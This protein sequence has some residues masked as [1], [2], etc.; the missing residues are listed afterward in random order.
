MKGSGEVRV[1]EF[2]GFVT[3]FHYTS[4]CFALSL[5][6]EVSLVVSSFIQ[7]KFCYIDFD[8]EDDWSELDY[9]WV[10]MAGATNLNSFSTL[11]FQGGGF[12]V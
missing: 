7:S 5:K 3:S 2:R 9:L 6:A 12:W 10:P 4:D 8:L 11:L 1:L